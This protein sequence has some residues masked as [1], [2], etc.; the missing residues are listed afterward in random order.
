MTEC[1]ECFTVGALSV[2]IVVVAWLLIWTLI[3]E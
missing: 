1:W 2:L 3:N